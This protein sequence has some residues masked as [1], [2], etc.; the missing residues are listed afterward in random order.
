MSISRNNFALKLGYVPLIDSAPLLVAEKEGFFK[1]E[2]VEVTLSEEVGWATVR[3]KMIHGELDMASSLI[4]LPYAIHNGVGC[5]KTPMAIPLILGSNGNSIVL[6]NDFSEDR[7]SDPSELSCALDKRAGQHDRKW[8][9]ATV[10]PY[11]S[12]LILLFQWLNNHL[13]DYISQ[14]EI[15]FIP[16]QLFPELLSQGMIDGFCAGEPWGS[17]AEDNGSGRIISSSRSLD[18]NHPEK[19]LCVPQRTLDYNEEG[20]KA[21]GKALLKACKKCNE[22]GYRDTLI[23]L[24]SEST[25]LEKSTHDI[26]KVLE[27]ALS[28][29]HSPH[30][31]K[32]YGTEVNKP[33]AEKEQWVLKGLKGSGLFRKKIIGTGQLM[34]PD[35]LF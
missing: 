21:V 3:D 12:H 10:N 13:K 15:V 9:F 17:I 20:V 18:P 25:S 35:L 26:N 2:R 32:F 30:M 1:E 29:E 5:Y 24:L 16:P 31:H 14:I 34:R 28:L 8:T 11:S 33:S 27:R 7:I 22:E 19:V 6:S 23:S 4:G